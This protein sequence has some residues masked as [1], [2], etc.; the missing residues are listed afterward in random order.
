MKDT[1][2]HITPEEKREIQSIALGVLKDELD[3]RIS[4]QEV[5]THYYADEED[6][7]R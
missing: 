5:L 6:L 2:R 7:E 3:H 1:E 4:L